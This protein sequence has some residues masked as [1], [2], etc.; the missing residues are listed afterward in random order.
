MKRTVLSLTG[1]LVVFLLSSSLWAAMPNAMQL[2]SSIDELTD[3]KGDVSA[4]VALTQQKVNQGTKYIEMQYFR[5]DRDDAFLILMKAPESDKGNGYLKAGDNFWM[6]RKNTRTFQHI[7]R[8]ESI[9]GTEA[10]ADDFEKRKLVEFYDILQDA[11][12]Q[13]ILEETMV[14]KIPVYR[15]ELKAKKKD[16]KYQ[17]RI[18]WV[19]K[20]LA[21]IVKEQG[22]S[23]S[24]RLINT[25]YYLKYTPL[26]GKYILTQAIFNDE[27]EK[28]NKTL[29]MISE[30]S[31]APIPASYLTKAYLENASK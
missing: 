25:S 19:R 28:G 2:L 4:K 9:G 14:G 11:S 27:F 26:N 6:Y 24:G 1:F 17:K 12:G 3:L 5:R 20:D 15:L 22:F 30:L 7:N 16:S 29:L 8:D 21:L 23:L 13:P 31:L 10:N 18:L